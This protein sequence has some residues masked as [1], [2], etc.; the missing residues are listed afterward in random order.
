LKLETDAMK[1]DATY[2]R[3]EKDFVKIFLV[4]CFKMMVL[5]IDLIS[6]P[7]HRRLC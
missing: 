4:A 5:V 3:K 7:R 6:P 1:Q 2:F